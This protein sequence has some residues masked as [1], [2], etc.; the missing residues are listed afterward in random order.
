[1]RYYVTMTVDFAGH[2]EADSEEEAEEKAWTAWG[3]TM[4]AELTY[5]GVND[6]RVEEDPESDYEDEDD[7]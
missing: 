6:I 1:M 4:D 2:I 7:E 3:D 5:D